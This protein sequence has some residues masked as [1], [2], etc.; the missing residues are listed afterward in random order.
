M[1]LVNI[2]TRTSYVFGFFALA[3]EASARRAKGEFGAHRHLVVN[4]RHIARMRITTAFL[5]LS[6]GG[7]LHAQSA[8]PVDTAHADSLRAQQLGRIVVSGARLAPSVDPRLPVRL[9][10]ITM[11]PSSRRRD[12]TELL[13]RMPG[14]SVSN[15]QGSHAQP[16]LDLR[17]F[18][19]SPVVGAPQGVSV[20]LDGVRVNE[21]DAQEVNF[22]LLPMEAVESAE[23]LSGPSAVFGKNSLAGSIQLRTARGGAAPQFT[24]QVGI[25]AFGEREAHLRAS[26]MLGATDGLVLVAASGDDGYQARSGARTRQLFA[27]I[28]RRRARSDVVL[29]LLVANDRVYEAGSLPE[30]WLGPARRA[31]YT[32]G[33]F[34]HPRLTQL[35]TRGTWTLGSAA[36]RANLFARRNEIE[37]YNV[38]AGAANTDAFVTNR[39]A[40]GTIELSTTRRLAGHALDLAIG[41]EATRSAVAYL[42]NAEPNPDS[43]GLPAECDP[44]ADGRSALC[45]DARVDG[46]DAG[47]YAQ[48]ILQATRRLALSLSTRGDWSRVPFRDRRDPS[49]DGTS[50]F[51]RLSPKL[52]VTYTVGRVRAYAAVGSAFRAP[53]ALE[54]AC[55]SPEAACP[56]PF[57][58]GDDP[59]LQPVVAWNYETGAEWSSGSGATL[60]L[61]LYD[62][63]VRNEIVFASATQV[64]GYF[65]N[66]PRSRRQGVETRFTALLPGDV[67]RLF[68]SYTFL[69]ATYRSTITLASALDGNDVEPG[70]HLA[71]SPR[72]RATLGI[73]AV[74]S[75]GDL[76]L[77]ATLQ[78]RGVS[79]SFLRGDEGNRQAPLPGYAVAD[80]ETALRVGRLVFTVSVSNLFDRRYVVYGVFA[81]NEKGPYGG[82]PP[83]TPE[84]ERFLTPAYPR[85]LRVGVGF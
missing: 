40:G 45:E 34:F 61:S 30:S 33:D 74:R 26:G 3:G 47:V 81:E 71:L 76:T 59:P 67:A 80:L 29:S 69:D 75:L 41:A 37:Q 6:C 23:L 48:G 77:D 22:D 2:M 50:I 49:N 52:G 79:S 35:S 5:L 32:G 21:P 7:S 55:A 53:A 63:E 27:N 56:L 31:N 44:A 84:V 78:A 39:S 60:S 25:G 73:N 16:S 68:G 65:N 82:P 24:G 8:P 58:L 43:P 4:A 19:L 13:V 64:A 11:P 14:V 83:S 15:D 20:F 42:V 36:L 70:D 10:R 1:S 46:V 57:S 17:G 28:G 85:V 18:T 51:T 62:T 72:H 9:E 12:A 54:L 66:V 38:N